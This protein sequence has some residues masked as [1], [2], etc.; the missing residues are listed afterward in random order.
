MPENNETTIPDFFTRF[1]LIT[2]T[3]PWVATFSNSEPETDAA[4]DAEDGVEVVSAAIG[5]IVVENNGKLDAVVAVPS[6]EKAY[7]YRFSSLEEDP[8]FWKFAAQFYFWRTPSV[9]LRKRLSQSL[10]GNATAAKGSAYSR[11]KTEVT[12]TLN[13]LLATLTPTMPVPAQMSLI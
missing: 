4:N 1:E 3:P 12:M 7:R 11:S 9:H 2:P 5:I 13:E 10:L 8:V 6:Q